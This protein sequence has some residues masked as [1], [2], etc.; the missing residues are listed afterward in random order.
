V[1]IIMAH[2]TVA[3]AKRAYSE[4][5]YY[6][7]AIY[8]LPL[9]TL[10]AQAQY[11]A[12]G[13]IHKPQQ[14]PYIVPTAYSGSLIQLDFGEVEEEKGFN[15]ITVEPGNPAQV[16]FKPLSCQKPLMVV[17]CQESEIENTLEAY[18]DQPGFLKVIVELETPIVGLSEKVRKICPQAL[19]VEAQ[20][21]TPKADTP[22]QEMQPFDPVDAFRHYWQEHIGTTLKPSVIEA[23]EQLYQE[24]AE[25]ESKNGQA[26]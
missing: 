9:Q 23:F 22:T 4:V 7:Q 5:D 2:L 25:S 1:N 12:L 3:K 18:Q 26:L 21:K 8:R 24:L 15:L 13:H 19:M 17:R 14:I 20:Y 11:I 16:E 6:T 10:P